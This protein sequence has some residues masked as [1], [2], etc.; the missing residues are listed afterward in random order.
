MRE[1]MSFSFAK[2]GPNPSDFFPLSSHIGTGLF[3]A[4]ALRAILPC[5]DCLLQLDQ[6]LVARQFEVVASVERRTDRNRHRPPP[7]RHEQRRKTRE[8]SRARKS[9]ERA[10]DADGDNGRL[11]PLDQQ[12][13][14]WLERVHLPRDGPFAL[15]KNEY[16]ASLAE[17]VKNGLQAVLGDP[18]L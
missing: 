2:N 3:A 8:L 16:G 10:G 7:R 18:L 14:A 13:N 4:E 17:Q 11:G 9:I 1:N 5:L 6:Q 15:G 12:L